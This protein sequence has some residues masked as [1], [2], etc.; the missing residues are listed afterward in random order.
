MDMDMYM[1][2]CA[3]ALVGAQLCSEAICCTCVLSIYVLYYYVQGQRYRSHY[4]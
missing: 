3:G 4:W 2:M 1:Y